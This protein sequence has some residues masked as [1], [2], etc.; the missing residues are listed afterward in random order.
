MDAILE[1]KSKDEARLAASDV[2]RES[3]AWN[4]KRADL[5][6]KRSGDKKS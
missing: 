2:V 4:S 6:G 3:E 1:A 5:R